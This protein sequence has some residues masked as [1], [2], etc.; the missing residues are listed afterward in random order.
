MV[1]Q[2]FWII[3]GRATVRKVVEKCLM[4]RHYCTKPLTQQIAPLPADRIIPAPPFTNIGLD[5]AGPLY[6]K[7][8]GAK[9]YICLFTCAVT[10][11]IHLELVSNMTMEKFLLALRR[12]VAQSGMCSIIWSDNAKTFKCA[13]ELQKC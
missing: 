4:C 10:R 13:K 12:M 6:L 11:A 3:K 7:D 8:G 1:R 9:A 5:F 2:K